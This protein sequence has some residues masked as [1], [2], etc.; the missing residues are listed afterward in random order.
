MTRD[1]ICRSVLF[2]RDTKLLF[3]VEQD[4]V[5]RLNASL[6]SLSLPLLDK[7]DAIIR[8]D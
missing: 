8:G 7:I 2:V 1:Q 3:L 4:G 6:V 5:F